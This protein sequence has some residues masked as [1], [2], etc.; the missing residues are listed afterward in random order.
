M[1]FEGNKTM[2]Q[3][4]TPGKDQNKLSQ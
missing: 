1:Y 4:E 3:H 2:L